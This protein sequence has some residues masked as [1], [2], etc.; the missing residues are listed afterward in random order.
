MTIRLRCVLTIG[1]AIGYVPVS[2]QMRGAGAIVERCGSAAGLQ[3]GAKG[4]SGGVG[5]GLVTV[6]AD[7]GVIREITVRR[8]G[9]F[10][11]RYIVIGQ[12][13]LGEVLQRYGQPTSSRNAGSTLLVDYAYDGITFTFPYGGSSGAVQ[14]N[15]VVRGATVH[16]KAR[17]PNGSTY[18]CTSAAK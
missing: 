6:T 5:D 14:N 7:R 12:S 8:A 3:L 9:A 13:T 18:P 15:L 1:I 10:T 4:A 16:D 2:A 17:L 11:Q